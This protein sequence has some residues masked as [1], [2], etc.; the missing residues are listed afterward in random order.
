MDATPSGDV[1]ISES[2]TSVNIALL[3]APCIRKA[4]IFGT[5]SPYSGASSGRPA[6]FPIQA[7]VEKK[8]EKGR[9]RKRPK[10]GLSSLFLLKSMK[11]LESFDF[12]PKKSFSVTKLLARPGLQNGHT[13]PS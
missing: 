9:A 13:S 3:D 8:I 10:R 4:I 6:P 11:I 12:E 2:A 7:G 5:R 1:P